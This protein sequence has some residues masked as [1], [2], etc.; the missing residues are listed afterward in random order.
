[1]ELTERSILGKVR[2]TFHSEEAKRV[3]ESRLAYMES[4]PERMEKELHYEA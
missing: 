3:A 4:F 1:M 2:G